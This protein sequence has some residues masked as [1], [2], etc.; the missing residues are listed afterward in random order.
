MVA[1]T[2]L[3]VLAYFLPSLVAVAR[4]HQSSLEIVTCNLL[5]GW[6]VLGWIAAF[7]WSLTAARWEAT[8]VV[9]E[10]FHSVDDADVPRRLSQ[11]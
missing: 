11:H 10:R 3:V 4:S 5:L 1:V 2:L 8:V 6:T 7:I 9:G